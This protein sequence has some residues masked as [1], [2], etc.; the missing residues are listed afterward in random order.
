MTELSGYANPTASI[1][2]IG[3]CA[4]PTT[5]DEVIGIEM[6]LNFQIADMKGR[7]AKLVVE[8]AQGVLISKTLAVTR[9]L[10]IEQR[11]K[12]F[13]SYAQLNLAP[14]RHGVEH[15][16]FT[17]SIRDTDRNKL[18]ANVDDYCI[19]L[20]LGTHILTKHA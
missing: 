6:Y 15:A 19:D 10:H 1:V 3:I 14:G 13:I 17:V 20:A 7:G 9:V 5:V 16:K 12:L 11:Y 8:F 4:E 2:H 18:L